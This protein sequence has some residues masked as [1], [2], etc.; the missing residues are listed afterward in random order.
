M[1]ECNVC[2]GKGINWDAGECDCHGSK[3]DECKK[4]GGSGIPV[5][6]LDCEGT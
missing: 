5:G 3:I 2:G 6:F 4:C 1:D